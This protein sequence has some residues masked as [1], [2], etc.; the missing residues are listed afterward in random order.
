[1]RYGIILVTVLLM[2][3]ASFSLSAQTSSRP[4]ARG[5]APDRV[6]TRSERL[7]KEGIALMKRGRVNPARAKF[8]EA[9]R[10]DPKNGKAHLAYANLL[11]KEGKSLAAYDHF[12]KAARLAPESGKERTQAR[13]V[14]TRIRSQHP[15]WFNNSKSKPQSASLPSAEPDETTVMGEKPNLAVFP[16]DYPGGDSTAQGLGT[17]FSEMVMT[18]LIN[19]GSYR[20]V[21]RRQIDRV[22]EE[23]A[24]G[25]TGTLEGETA[26][27]VGKI[28]GVQAV[29]VGNL[30]RLASGFESDVRVLNVETGEALLAGHATAASSAQFR[31]AAETLAATLSTEVEKVQHAVTKDSSATVSQ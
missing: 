16:F 24:L 10:L 31:A 9:L 14:I 1:M 27:A 19:R 6:E 12:T 7:T 17:T 4:I 18:A 20:I 30:S 26:V 23:Q 29:A 2:F 15:E 13:Q 28:L 21:E 3:G 11:M 5:T 22:F 8:Q 25:Q